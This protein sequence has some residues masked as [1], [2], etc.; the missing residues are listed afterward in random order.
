MH[1]E[2]DQSMRPNGRGIKQRKG[3]IQASVSRRASGRRY[4]FQVDTEPKVVTEILC[5]GD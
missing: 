1:Q 4:F 2:R 5:L 3:D